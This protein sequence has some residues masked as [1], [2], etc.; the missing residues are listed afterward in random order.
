MFVVP[1]YTVLPCSMPVIPVFQ[2]Q[3][4][5]Q[6]LAN[7]PSLSFFSSNKINAHFQGE[8]SI[9]LRTQE[10]GREEGEKD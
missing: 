2:H 10:G 4:S 6:F 8:G 1:V 9:A 3:W 5:G 7:F